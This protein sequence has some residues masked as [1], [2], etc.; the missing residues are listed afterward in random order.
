MKGEF[1]DFPAFTPKCELDPEWGLNK[2]LVKDCGNPKMGWLKKAVWAGFS[3]QWPKAYKLIQSINFDNQ[4][5]SE[6]SAL[7]IV[8]GYSEEQ[9][10]Q[11]WLKKYNLQASSWL[12]QANN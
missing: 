3:Q 11:V 5:I 12:A 2:E 4:M 9:A 6:A 10:A 1:I 7:V 8:D